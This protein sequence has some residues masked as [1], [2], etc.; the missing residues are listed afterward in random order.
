MKVKKNKYED[1][2]W[3]LTFVANRKEVN[4]SFR[5]IARGDKL[6][7]IFSP[8]NSSNNNQC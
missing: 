4:D 5:W 2:K 8:K 6:S 1:K 3:E 7:T